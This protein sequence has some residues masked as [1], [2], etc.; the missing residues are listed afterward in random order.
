LDF[1]K[2]NVE[3]IGVKYVDEAL[4]LTKNEIGDEGVKYINEGL[5]ANKALIK[6]NFV[7]MI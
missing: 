5:E 4:D 3:A 1:S 7:T 6:L 2:S